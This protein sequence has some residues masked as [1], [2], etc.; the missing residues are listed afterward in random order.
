MKSRPIKNKIDASVI[1]ETE[2]MQIAAVR[3]LSLNDVGVNESLKNQIEFF[4]IK[5][6]VNKIRE[7][8]KGVIINS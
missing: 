8:G 3:G 5:R 4:K 6:E 1:G 7:Q 2:A